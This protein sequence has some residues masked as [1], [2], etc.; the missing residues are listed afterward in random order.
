VKKIKVTHFLIFLLASFYIQGYALIQPDEKLFQEAKILIFDKEW[1]RAQERLEELIEE[2][3]ESPWY[4]QALF[5]RAKCLEEQAG[6]EI[7]A[8]EAYRE[9]LKLEDLRPSLAEE[10][11]I[12]VI[13]LAYELYRKGK[14]SYLKDI[15]RKLSSPNKV[16]KYY[17]AF[18]LSYVK[19]KK[20]A[21]KGIPALKEILKRERDAELRDRAKIALLRVDPKALKDFEEERYERRLRILKIRVYKSG[22]KEPVISIN[23][24]WGLADLALGAI[25]DEEKVLIKEKGY[26]LDRIRRELTRFDGSILEIKGE[27][28]TIKMWI[29]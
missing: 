15:E 4:P 7:E 29:D 22:K 5:Y 11:E 2:Y 28:T 21:S 16:V 20:A 27:D 10:S 13:D 25:P 1:E 26:D 12:S 24:P 18:K 6:K 3:P 8:L 17:A 9:F 19:D 14:K 23:I